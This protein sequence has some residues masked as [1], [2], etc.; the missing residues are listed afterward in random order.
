MSKRQQVVKQVEKIIGLKAQVEDAERELDALLDAKKPGRKP[1]AKAAKPKKVPALDAGVD[2][3]TA[4]R[5]LH[6]MESDRSRSFTAL[7]AVERL[8]ITSHA[9]SYNV[10]NLIKAKKVKKVKRGHYQV[11]GG[12]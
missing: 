10:N 4:D 9:F 11:R 12:K 7:D 1:G 2:V 5:I 8:E 3:S 6:M